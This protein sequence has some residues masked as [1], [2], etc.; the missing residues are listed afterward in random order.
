MNFRFTKIKVIGSIA[1]P[2]IVWIIIFI[3]GG[4]NSLLENI[5]EII[6][7]FLSV[8]DIE[9]IFSFGNISLF[10]IEIMVVYVIWSLIQKKN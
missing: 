8:H 7:K 6:S 2:V 3:I 4:I 1:I 10:I 5:P 9:N